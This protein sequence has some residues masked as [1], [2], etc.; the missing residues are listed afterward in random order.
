MTPLN[1]WIQVRNEW[2]KLEIDHNSSLVFAK[3]TEITFSFSLVWLK[4]KLR[5]TK[6]SLNYSFMYS[7][8]MF[9][10]PLEPFLTFWDSFTVLWLGVAQSRKLLTPKSLLSL[11]I[12]LI[13][14]F[15]YQSC[16]S[17]DQIIYHW[18]AF[19]I[20]IISCSF[21]LLCLPFFCFFLSVCSMMLRF[22]RWC[23]SQWW[24]RSK[25]VLKQRNNLISNDSRLIHSRLLHFLCLTKRW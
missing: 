10:V 25:E 16:Q 13:H 9:Q 15:G 22:E 19:V 12:T 23:A 20:L 7:F 21:L 4:T 11:L 2:M 1:D 8:T 14:L 3:V 18:M 24:W 5:Q 17:S 6:T